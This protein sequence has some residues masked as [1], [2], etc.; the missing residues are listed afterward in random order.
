[1]AENYIG[2]RMNCITS[3]RDSRVV[4]RDDI[5]NQSSYSTVSLEARNHVW[6]PDIYINLGAGVLLAILACCGVY[7]KEEYFQDDD[8]GKIQGLV[9]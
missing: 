3:W 1:M 4:L 6:M 8:D 5:Y 7:G 2:F 9:Q